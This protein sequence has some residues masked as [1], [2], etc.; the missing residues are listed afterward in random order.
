MIL[1]KDDVI[2]YLGKGMWNVRNKTEQFIC[3]T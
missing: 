3:N 2:V 1:N